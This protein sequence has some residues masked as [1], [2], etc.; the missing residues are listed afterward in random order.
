MDYEKFLETKKKVIE[1]NGIHIDKKEF[2]KMLFE[3]Q[4]D[5]TFCTLKKG[6]YAVWADCGLG[7]TPMQLEIANQVHKN[8]KGNVLILAPLAVTQQTKREG[9]KFGIDV[10][11]CRTQEDAVNGIN[12]TNYEMLEH[13]NAE[14][15]ECIILDE[16]S[17][18]KSF[19]SKTKLA[20]IEKFK[21][22]PYRFSYTA[23][24]SPNDIEEL[25]NQA[26]FLGIMSRK[27]MLSTYF[28]HDGGDT[29]KWRL[30]GHAKEVFW[31][32]VANWAVVITKPSDLGYGDN[33]FKL[34]ALN[35]IEHKTQKDCHFIGEQVS[36]FAQTALSLVE[37]RN[38]RRE[39]LS[40]RVQITADIVNNSTEQ[41]IVW[42]DLNAESE[43][44][45]KAIA[46]SVEVKGSDKTDHKI[47]SALDFASGKIRVII[48]KPSIFGWGINWQQCHNMCFVGLSDSYEQFY[49]AVRRCYR[50]GQTKEVNVHIVISEKEGAVLDNIKRKENQAE[51]MIR[52]MVKYTHLVL[53]KEIRGIT[54][55]VIGYNP[56]IKMI[57]PQWLKVG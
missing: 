25:G 27:E 33:N 14:A 47:N 57:L 43:A 52:E 5:I 32:W 1:E 50:F 12:I 6:R 23:T 35:M 17:I 38:A 22:T 7:K 31:E 36:L 13:F 53:E 4:K 2:N 21:N 54:R 28:V 39:T 34:P 48:S 8:T 3:F 49:Q 29:S 51:E 26:E 20:L 46:G 42:C 9:E 30:K 41:F 55:E 18:L 19:N 37:R 45:K 44:L 15:F 24:P 56:Q 16:S 11:I 10:N 40:E